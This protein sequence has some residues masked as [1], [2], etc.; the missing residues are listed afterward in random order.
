VNS[1]VSGILVLGVVLTAAL[2]YGLVNFRRQFIWLYTYTAIIWLVVVLLFAVS[3]P[4]HGLLRIVYPWALPL[5]FLLPTCVQLYTNALFKTKSEDWV[6]YV[7]YLMPIFSMASSYPIITDA[8]LYQ[9]NVARLLAGEFLDLEHSL[10]VMSNSLIYLTAFS[11]M[12]SVLLMRRV[13]DARFT[14]PSWLY[15]CLPWLQLILSVGGLLSILVHGLGGASGQLVFILL[16]VVS[17]ALG[18]YVVLLSRYEERKL[19]SVISD[20]MFFAPSA[21]GSIENFLRNLDGDAVRAL[22]QDFTKSEL[23]SISLIS[24]TEWESFF[25]EQRFSW[26]EFKNRVRVRYALQELNSGF[27]ATKTV[28][29]LSLELGFQSR[30]SFYTAYESVTG[31]MFRAEVYR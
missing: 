24:T 29:S 27:L 8:T 22:F 19:T 14:G 4:V 9:K 18:T 30:K 15:W 16:S 5:L 17:I 3:M 12:H 21:H 1:D 13:R 7:L 28:E 6:F 31:E 11:T 10:G 20:A 23:A 26:P 25:D 2:V